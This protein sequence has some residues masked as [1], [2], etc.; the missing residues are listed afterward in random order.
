MLQAFHR[1]KRSNFEEVGGLRQTSG[2]IFAVC[3]VVKI[4][5]I[6]FVENNEGKEGDLLQGRQ[7]DGRCH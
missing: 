3:I 2:W 1:S 5:W 7:I 4:G 6:H